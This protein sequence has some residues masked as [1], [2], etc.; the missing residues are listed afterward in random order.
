M[1]IVYFRWYTHRNLIIAGLNHLSLL[2][3]GISGLLQ[4]LELWKKTFKRTGFLSN[5]HSKWKLRM[6]T[7]IF[8]ILV[9]WFFSDH[10]IS[11]SRLKTFFFGTTRSRSWWVSSLNS[12]IFDMNTQNEFM[13]NPSKI[14]SKVY[15]DFRHRWESVSKFESQTLCEFLD[16]FK[17]F[18]DEISLTM[19]NIE[20]ENPNQ[21]IEQRKRNCRI[22]WNKQQWIK[23]SSSLCTNVRMK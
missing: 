21:K 17:Q 18:L 7:L 6:G 8:I 4:C 16:W 22:K 3:F 1:C 14:W 23:P 13:A 11:L 10:M 15:S 2:H 5:L 12:F 20:Y 19:K 9:N